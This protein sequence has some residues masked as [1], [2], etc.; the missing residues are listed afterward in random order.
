MKSPKV[1]VKPKFPVFMY[2][3]QPYMKVIP[4][5]RLFNSTM[6][7]EVCTRGDFFAVNMV[8][9]VFTILPNGA[10]GINHEQSQNDNQQVRSRKPISLTK[11]LFG[12]K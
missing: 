5:K 11:D 4:A 2:E 9:N 1:K 8:T 12:D 6:I 3:D 10:D 7:H